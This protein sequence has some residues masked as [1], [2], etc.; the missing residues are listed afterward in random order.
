MNPTCD[1][2][3]LLQLYSRCISS[4]ESA[5]ELSKIG[6]ERKKQRLDLYQFLAGPVD[7][8]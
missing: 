1:H 3:D 6:T 8:G 4:F 5:P 7:E 2:L